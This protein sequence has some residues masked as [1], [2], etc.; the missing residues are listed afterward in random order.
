[1]SHHV[2]ETDVYLAVQNGTVSLYDLFE[3]LATRPGQGNEEAIWSHT[4]CLTYA[5]TY[6]RIHQYAQWFLAQG[7]KPGQ[8]VVFYMGNTPDFCCAWMGLMAIGAAPALINTNLAS[9]AL[10]HCINIA[11]SELLLADGDAELL[12]RIDDEKPA[13]EASGLRV[14]HLDDVRGQIQSLKPTRPPSELRKGM[15]GSSPL[16]LA[17]TRFVPQTRSKTNAD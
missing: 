3:E 7:V 6:D 16:A 4:E 11:Q 10:I 8:Y 14:V 12:T 5:Q 13:L 17:Y 2:C 9:K 1:M 15:V